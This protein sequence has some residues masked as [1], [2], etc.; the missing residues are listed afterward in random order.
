MTTITARR[1]LVPTGWLDGVR[2]AIDRGMVTG[3][4]SHHGSFD[5][6]TVCPGFVDLQVNGIDDIDCSAA[7]D[8]QWARL[9]ELL[10][11]QGTTAWCP[12]LVT[13]PL[14][15]YHR[16]LARIGEAIQAA[17][18]G[19]ATI[20][21]AHLEGPFLGGAPGAHPPWLLRDVDLDWLA[22]LP[23][24]VRMVTLAAERPAA[25]AATRLLAERGVLVSM[26]HTTASFEQLDSCAAAGASMVTHLCNGMSGLHHRSP[27][28]A[29]WALAH[30]TLSASVIAD[31]VHVHP[32]MLGLAARLLGTERLVLV[33]DSVAWRAGTAGAIGLEMRDGAP[34]LADGTLAGSAVTMDEAVRTCVAAGIAVEQAL[35][36][37]SRNP[38]RLACHAAGEL[39][40]GAPADLVAL[41]AD[42]GVQQVWVGGVPRR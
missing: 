31:G 1:A 7:R 2:L 38:A 37:A 16:P 14:E 9:D 40:L 27:G 35:W 30:E 18:P 24:H 10:V 29:A 11:A 25:V 13:M 33:T 34:R 26:G 15:S 17:S 39:R 20:L 23:A 42:L 36:A 3:I 4:E 6:H 5:V 41:D 8:G 21:G 19:S 32:L 22:S 28:V 12:T